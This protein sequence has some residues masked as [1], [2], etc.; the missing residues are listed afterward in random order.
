[1]TIQCRLVK[2]LNCHALQGVDEN[3]NKTLG[4]SPK[5]GLAKANKTNN[6]S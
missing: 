6:Y 2:C 4:F 5:N 3:R 1:M